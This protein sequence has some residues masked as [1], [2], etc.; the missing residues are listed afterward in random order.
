MAGRQERKKRT[1]Y[2]PIT[3]FF[4]NNTAAYFDKYLTLKLKIGD[5]LRLGSYEI[6]YEL[7]KIGKEKIEELVSFG[8][9]SYTIKTK[10]QELA[11]RLLKLDEICQVK[12]EIAIHKYYNSIQALIYL[13]AY[14]M[15]SP[16][17]FKAEMRKAHESIVDIEAADF[18]K[19]R[20]LQGRALLIT[21]R[22]GQ[23]PEYISIPGE[24]VDAKVISFEARP[25][26]CKNCHKYGHEQNKCSGM[27]R[28][29]RCSREGHVK[30]ECQEQAF[31]FHCRK[32][33]EIGS[34]EC[35]TEAYE[36][37]IIKTHEAHK[38][39][40]FRAKQILEDGIHGNYKEPPKHRNNKM[41]I[42]IKEGD[43]SD[44]SQVNSFTILHHVTRHLGEKPIT[45]RRQQS[46]YVVEL[47]GRDQCNKLKELREIKGQE[48]EITD[49][50]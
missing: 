13:Q 23:M 44:K 31:C 21:F 30:Q 35:A 29:G 36:R 41:T 24:P 38:V 8:V 11:E 43:D 16:E 9:D 10:G 1:T 20:N 28:C 39:G 33:H 15:Y 40:R 48:C 4:T 12:S 50:N 42:R 34:R 45:V 22:R 14:G 37:A 3:N 32:G 2:T 17:E 27:L 7:E 49:H 25:K 46:D 6:K 26:R 19:P 18:I 47:K 5:K